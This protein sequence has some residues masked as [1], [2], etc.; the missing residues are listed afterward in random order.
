[1]QNAKIQQ[2]FA[3]LWGPGA[4]AVYNAKIQK[5]MTTTCIP[6]IGQWQQPQAE[7]SREPLGDPSA[8]VFEVFLKVSQKSPGFVRPNVA[9]NPRAWLIDVDRSEGKFCFRASSALL[10][11]A[12]VRGG[13]LLSSTEGLSFTLI[14][15][16]EP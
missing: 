6:P 4:Y 5:K 14:R 3:L 16:L 9:L 13:G 12:L 8:R 10:S 1:M 11:G 2:R 15:T 7:H